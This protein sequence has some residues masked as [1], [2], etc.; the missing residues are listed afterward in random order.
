MIVG[1]YPRRLACEF[2][3]TRL[4]GQHRKRQRENTLGT[5]GKSSH[6]GRN[7]DGRRGTTEKSQTTLSLAI[8][9][10]Y[11]SSDRATVHTVVESGSVFRM[12]CSMARRLCKTYKYTLKRSVS[13]P[14]RG[15]APPS[16]SDQHCNGQSESSAHRRDS[17]FL[18]SRPPAQETHRPIREPHVTVLPL[19]PTASAAPGHHEA[20]ATQGISASACMY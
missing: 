9:V 5:S 19:S 7:I 3:S 11:I 18:G 12:A 16:P 14:R 13:R 8:E 20:L 2:P 6:H 10:I 15:G 4:S 17:Q 1:G